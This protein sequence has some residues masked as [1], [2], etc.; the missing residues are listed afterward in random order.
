MDG[1]GV[2]YKERGSNGTDQ[3]NSMKEGCEVMNSYVSYAVFGV[4]KGPTTQRDTGGDKVLV[5]NTL[6]ERFS[7]IE[8]PKCPTYATSCHIQLTAGTS[9]ISRASSS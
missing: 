9:V 4:Y 6:L 7:H 1:Y 8:T 2:T 3:R 5:Q